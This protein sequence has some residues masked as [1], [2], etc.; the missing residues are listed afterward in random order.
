MSWLNQYLGA[1]NPPSIPIVVTALVKRYTNMTKD[2]FT[3][4]RIW[5]ANK[6]FQYAKF[7][8]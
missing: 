7:Y 6:S 3:K 1:R 2:F 4:K 8:L 5:K